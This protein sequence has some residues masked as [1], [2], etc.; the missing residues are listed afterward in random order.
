MWVVYLQNV[1]DVYILFVRL[2]LAPIELRWTKLI[3]YKSNMKVCTISSNMA[4]VQ[5]NVLRGSQFTSGGVRVCVNTL[6]AC[7]TYSKPKSASGW[8]PGRTPVRT[9]LFTLLGS[10]LFLGRRLVRTCWSG[11]LRFL[12]MR[13][14]LGDLQSSINITITLIHSWPWPGCS[15]AG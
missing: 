2:A 7:V 11:M 14:A 6:K 1:K 10:F 5:T 8:S 4:V 12:R 9:G 13:L 15:K 3:M